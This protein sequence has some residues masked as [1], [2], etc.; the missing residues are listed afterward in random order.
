M[1]L[2]KAK[3]SKKFDFIL[4]SLLIV[5]GITSII[6]IF[7]TFGVIGES[8]GIDYVTK[9]FMWYSIGFVALLIICYIGNDHI[10][11]ITK[12]CYF[13]L[14]FLLALL[15]IDKVFH[16]MTGSDLPFMNTVNGSTSWYAIPGLGSFQ[17]SEFMK[18][19]IIILTADTIEKHFE[20][21]DTADF[22]S[23]MLLFL[24][25]FRWAIPP[26]ILILLQPDTGI[27]IIIGISLIVMLACSG[28]RK[29][30]FIVGVILVAI[31]LALFS[32]M[33]LFH[34]EVLNDLIGG[35]GGYKL[36][37]I[38]SWLNPE[39]DISG[40]GMQLYTAL[41]TLGSA[42]IFGHGPQQMVV[43]I[44]EA[45]TDFIF[46]IIGQSF[47]FIGALFVIGLCLTLD[48]Y[49]CYIASKTK[50][51]NE[52]FIVIGVVAI[53]IYPQVQNIGMIIGLLPITGITLPLISYGGSSLLSY[54][55]IFGVIMNISNR[56]LN[57]KDYL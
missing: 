15:L 36:R 1:S 9:Q 56:N 20:T 11:F 16:D 45:Q 34:F 57:L 21:I 48:L 13:I 17:P 49:L 14:F 27:C 41:L 3:S 23:D 24:K 8:R 19:C 47:G 35:D 2:S 44:P 30:W 51:I 46:A 26:M 54:F 22:Q 55:L 18:L 39:S 40:D 31:V 28:I 4:L 32:Y 42:G 43:A 50:I 52:K 38:T 25:V 7:S 10:I 33:Y 12:I 5:I 6:A 29:E 53:L 37:R